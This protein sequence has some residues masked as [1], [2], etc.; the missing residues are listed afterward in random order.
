VRRLAEADEELAR[1][2]D[3]LALQADRGV[4]TR[5]ELNARFD[6]TALA[7]AQASA[8]SGEGSWIDRAL[9]RLRSLVTVRPVGKDVEGDSADARLARAES[10]LAEGDFAA[11]VTELE[12]LDGAA[13]DAA[14]PWL[15]DARARIAAEEAVAR[16][17]AKALARISPDGSSPEGG[18]PGQGG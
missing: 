16:L 11:A 8:G 17:Q 14:A 4:P 5:V 6:E 15:A 7:I 13:S 12:G 18:S 10:R 1:I 3:P 9:A 2:L